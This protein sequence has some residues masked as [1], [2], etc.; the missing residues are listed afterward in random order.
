M[1]V[2]LV[3]CVGVVSFAAVVAAQAPVA[4]P[5]VKP[6]QRP[7][8]PT[9]HHASFVRT[10]V[11]AF[12]LA[13]LE[14]AGLRPAREAG[15]PTLLRRLH[16]DLIGLPPT[17]AEVEAFVADPA[18]DAYE[19]CVEQL[20]AS[21]QYGV[22]WAQAWLDLV[23]YAETD[24]Y[25]RDRRKPEV[26]RYRD[27]VVEALNQDLPYGEFVA[28]QLAGDER[29][30]AS[31]ADRIAT[32]YHRLGIWDDEP[33]DH[34]QHRYDDL[35]GIA[36]TTARAFLGVSMGCARCHDHKVEPLPPREY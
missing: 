3:R 9:V 6:L 20:L 1:L 7:A 2:R 30:D 5:A 21:P 33:S 28:R 10:P 31:V 32:G 23:R 4:V 25:E 36:D 19:R 29:P 16:Y 26:W 8:V 35:D 13:R 12:V 34:E 18:P 15:R 22:K 11:D 24:G 17:P 14:A 27:W